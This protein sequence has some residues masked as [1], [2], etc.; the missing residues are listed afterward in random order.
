MWDFLDL[1][2]EKQVSYDFANRSSVYRL[3]LW[4]TRISMSPVSDWP[5]GRAQLLKATILLLGAHHQPALRFDITTIQLQPGPTATSPRPNLRR[6]KT[7]SGEALEGI[8]ENRGSLILLDLANQSPG[9]IM[10][11]ISAAK[12]RLAP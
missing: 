3:V 5:W 12:T 2:S 4:L 10:G 7:R 9:T 8:A 1:L 11:S 6:V